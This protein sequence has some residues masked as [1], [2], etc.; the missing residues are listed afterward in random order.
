MA[1]QDR[2]AREML[3]GNSDGEIR[4]ALGLGFPAQRGRERRAQ[5]GALGR[6]Q[7]RRTAL[8]GR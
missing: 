1:M 4:R 2:I 7:D 3:D 6:I 8:K 5:G